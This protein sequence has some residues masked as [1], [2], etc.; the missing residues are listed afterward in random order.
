MKTTTEVIAPVQPSEEQ[1]VRPLSRW[2]AGLLAGSWIGGLWWAIAVQPASDPEAAISVFATFASLALWSLV[3]ATVV[4]ALR[5]ERWAVTTS[6]LGAIALLA[7]VGLCITEGHTGAWVFTQA[8]IGF[9]I[10]GSTRIAN[11]I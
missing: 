9:G 3:G 1:A 6:A 2:S 5:R 11:A 7:T 10:L 8:A 4:G